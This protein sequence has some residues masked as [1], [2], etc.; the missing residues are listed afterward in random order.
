MYRY[1]VM[2]S[3]KRGEMMSQLFDTFEEAHQRMEATLALD[4]GV[5]LISGRVEYVKPPQKCIINETTPH[6][7]YS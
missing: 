2:M 3:W 4:H 1:F 5:T 6:T 7:I